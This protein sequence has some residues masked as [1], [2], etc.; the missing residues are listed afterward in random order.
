MICWID[1]IDINLHGTKQ[2]SNWNN[3]SENVNLIMEIDPEW[4]AMRLTSE[5]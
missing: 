4:I 1:Q 3:R 5:T 2:I